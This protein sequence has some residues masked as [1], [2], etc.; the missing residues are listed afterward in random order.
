MHKIPISIGIIGHLDAIIEEKHIQVIRELLDDIHDIYP[1]S[2][3]SMFSQLA[4]GADTEVAKLFLQIKN[5]TNREY[6]LVV[7]LPFILEEYKTLFTGNELNEFETLLS[8]AERYYVIENKDGLGKDELY[9]R[10]GEFIADSSII[11]IALWEDIE[12]KKVGGTADIVKYKLTGSYFDDVEDHIFDL[13]GSLISL[14]CNRKSTQNKREIVLSDKALEILIKDVSIKKSLDKI[15]EYNKSTEKMDIHELEQS[16]NHLFP[17]EKDLSEPNQKL[18]YYYSTID[19]LAIKHQKRY[20]YLITGLFLLGFI[21]LCVFEGYKHLGLNEYVFA[22]TFSLIM[23]AFGIFSISHR[24]KNHEKYIEDR[25]VA[26]ALRIQFFWN[27][28]D[29]NRSVS[30]YI[31]RIHKTEYNWV[32]HILLSIY[33]LTYNSM[34]TRQETIQEVKNH[35][36]DNQY[37]YFDNNLNKIS[38]KKHL[39]DLVSYGSLLMAILGLVGIF[40]LTQYDPHHESLHIMVVIDSIFFGIFALSKAYYQKKGYE[41]IK[42]QFS[43]MQSVYQSTSNKMDELIASNINTKGKQL[44]NL[45]YLAGKEALI[46]NGNW[47]LIFKGKEPEVEGLGG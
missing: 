23:I 40:L 2:P 35:W 45:L 42:N 15:E 21:V 26:E 46:E 22:S 7:P 33:G 19:T 8:K 18:K 10:G 5:E 34:S 1:N 30:D 13:N 41:Q 43:L 29:I 4:R 14:S 37:Q 38:K 6:N 16:K 9:R 24:W 27:L 11:L 20:H 3:V 39:F 28:S 36:I 31:L 12:N 47:Y 44:D 17:E 25:V 32:Q